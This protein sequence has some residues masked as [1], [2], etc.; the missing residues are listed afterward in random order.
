LKQK[1]QKKQKVKS[2]QRLLCRTGL[3]RTS[4]QSH[5]YPAFAAALATIVLSTFSE[6]ALL[7]A[8]GVSIGFPDTCGMVKI[9]CAL[10]NIM[11]LFI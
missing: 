4:G 2:A 3:L 7:T 8:F 11:R 9:F 5:G 6:A 10:R 1:K